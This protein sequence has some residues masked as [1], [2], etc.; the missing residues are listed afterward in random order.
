MKIKLS[1]TKNTRD[2]SEY[3]LPGYIRSAHLHDITEEDAEVLVGKYNLKTVIDLRTSMEAAE[4]PNYV[5]P[6]VEYIHMPLFDEAKLGISHEKSVDREMIAKQI[7]DMT[8]LYR[9]LIAEPTSIEQIKKVMGIIND[10]QREGAVLWH[11]TE[12]KDRCGVISAL[13]LMSSGADYKTVLRD[14]L[15]TNKANRTKAYTYYFM[16]WFKKRD[17]ALAGKIRDMFLAKKE[18]LDA[19]YE[20]LK[21]IQSSL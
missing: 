21:V 8:S 3:G 20:E 19:V 12:G 18:Y 10:P 6:G 5:I 16:I 4:K 13:V 11:C 17:K 9:S 1:G 2:F 14:Y 7:P 15:K